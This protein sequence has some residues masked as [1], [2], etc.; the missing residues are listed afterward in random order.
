MLLAE[1]A[2]IRRGL[3]NVAHSL[4]DSPIPAAAEGL[5]EFIRGML[6]PICI[7]MDKEAR[8]QPALKAQT[9]F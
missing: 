6:L 2:V 4:H 5:A 7:Q 3:R 9:L 1:G 8:Y